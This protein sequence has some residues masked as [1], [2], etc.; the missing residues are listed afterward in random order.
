MRCFCPDSTCLSLSPQSP[1]LQGH[2]WGG[3]S[4]EKI[5]PCCVTCLRSHGE[6]WSYPL[7]PP[8]S[9]PSH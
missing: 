8:L 1:T 5:P 9:A 6:E 4:V 7:S 3:F 2:T